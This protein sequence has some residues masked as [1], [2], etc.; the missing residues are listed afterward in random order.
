[1]QRGTPRPSARSRQKADGS[2][3][4]SRLEAETDDRPAAIA[5]A[6]EDAATVAFGNVAHDRETQSGSGHRARLVGAVEPFEHERQLC[7]RD[8]GTAVCDSDPAV[9]HAHLDRRA[10]TI[11]LG[12]IVE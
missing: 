12:R 7:L 11:E 2:N 10:R 8:A 3:L 4:T 6:G 9:T 1:M 5:V